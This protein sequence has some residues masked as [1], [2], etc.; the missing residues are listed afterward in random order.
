MVIGCLR[1]SDVSVI[2]RVVNTRRT[3]QKFGS[4]S[5]TECIGH[6]ND[7]ELIPTVKMKTINP[8]ACYFGSEFP[9]FYNRC[10]VM[11]A[12]NRKTLKFCN[13]FLRF[14][15]KNDPLRYNFPNSG[16]KIFIATPIDVVMFKFR[17][18]W[19]TDVYQNRIKRCEFVRIK[20]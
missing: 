19:Q 15:W 9:S 17:E 5:C 13:K 1:L 16:P 12:W 7:F 10:W 11:A 4:V 20:Y 14:C 2:C 18:I 8:V 6:G 3:S